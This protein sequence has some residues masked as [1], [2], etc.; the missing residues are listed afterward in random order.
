GMLAMLAE[1][2]SENLGLETKKG[3]A[4]RKAKGL[5]NGL[6][7][8]GYR[9]ADGDVAGHDPETRDGVVL[10]F[11]MAAAGA[12]LSAIAQAL[13]ARGYRTAGNMRR[14]VSTKDTVRDMLG[15]RFYLGKLPVFEPRARRRVREW[16]DGCHAPLADEQLF[17]AARMAIQGRAT[18]TRANRRNA[19]VYSL[20][21]LLRCAHCRE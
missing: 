15:N 18:A 19:T 16:Q 2:Y 13:N 17:N 8:F 6:V 21:G 20:S 1:Y 10:A 11:A 5:H 14:G 4:E 12:S 7:P 3:K 9:S